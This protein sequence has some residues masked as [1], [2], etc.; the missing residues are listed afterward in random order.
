MC[1]Y[2]SSQKITCQ[3]TKPKSLQNKNTPF[4]SLPSPTAIFSAYR[5][6]P[7]STVH[8]PHILLSSPFLTYIKP[9]L[10]CIL[11]H[12]S[13]SLL[14]SFHIPMST[15]TPTPVP[16]TVQHVPKKSSDE[17]LA[18]FA[19]LSSDDHKNKRRKKT[20][21]ETPSAALV[22]RRSLLPPALTRKSALL[23][24]L[25]I[26]RVRLKAR[27]LRNK[28]L[29]ATIDKVTSTH[30]LYYLPLFIYL[31]LNDWTQCLVLYK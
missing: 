30:S 16:A 13:V 28:S 20:Q 11:L 17:L 12:S 1:L 31:C 14:C 10:S 23:R 26:G 8:I 29:L 9:H 6:P 18:K 3:Y 5:V 19:Q 4:W 15:P 21:S 24:Q 7:S 2:Y 25:G 22:E 27:D